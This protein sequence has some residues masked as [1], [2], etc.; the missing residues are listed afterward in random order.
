[1]SAPVHVTNRA[2]V[3]QDDVHVLAACEDRTWSL[4]DVTQVRACAW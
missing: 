2:Q 4:W 3:M 1:M